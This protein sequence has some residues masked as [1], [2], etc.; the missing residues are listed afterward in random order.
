[1]QS[2]FCD[3]LIFENS[4]NIFDNLNGNLKYFPLKSMNHISNIK[5]NKKNS[6]M[7]LLY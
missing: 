1:M 2:L 5:K 7:F 3:R 4:H 6:I